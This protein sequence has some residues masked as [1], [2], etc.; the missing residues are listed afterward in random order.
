MKRKSASLFLGLI[1]ACTTL[2]GL[3]ASAQEQNTTDQI[4]WQP[5]R[6]FDTGEETSVSIARNGNYIVE[7]HQSNST[8]R[9]WYH[10][11][12]LVTQWPSGYTLSWGKSHNLDTNGEWPAVTVT[13]EGYVILVNS[14]GGQVVNQIV[15]WVGKINLVGG[16]DQDIQWYIKAQPFGYGFHPSVTVD[17]YGKIALVYEC[18]NGCSDDLNYRV[19]HL[20]NPAAGKYSI[21]WDSGKDAV[22]YD[23]GVNPHIAINDN[24][25]VIE[26]HQVGAKEQLLHYRRGSLYST[27]IDFLDSVRYDNNGRQPAVTLTN[28]GKVVE[29]HIYKD[30]VYARTATYDANDP[31]RV[32]WSD[33]VEISKERFNNYPAI[34]NNNIQVLSTWTAGNNPFGSPD[35]LQYSRA[36]VE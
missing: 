13:Q 20:E 35:T 22:Q 25:Q 10:V 33:S 31:S 2:I 28:N 11:G 15:Y 16:I 34:T 29:T 8:R 30:S 32:V 24:G 1:V 26:V 19:G 7:I 6:T 18:Q 27:S 4:N 23:R 17:S 9:M 3:K 21:V 14:P 36:A 12:R 5:G